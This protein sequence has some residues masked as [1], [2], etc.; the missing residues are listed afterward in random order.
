MKLGEMVT[1][2]GLE[3]VSL[4]GNSPVQFACVQWLLWESW[5]WQEHG[6]ILSLSVLAAIIL[7]RLLYLGLEMEGP[8]P[9]VSWAFHLLNGCHCPLRGG[10]SPRCWSRSIECWVW[11]YSIPVCA[12]SSPSNGTYTQ[13]RIALGVRESGLCTRCG[14]ECTLAGPGTKAQFSCSVVSDSLQPH[15]PQHARPPCPLPTPR[16]HSH[17]C[18]LSQWCHPTISYSVVPFSSH[19]Q[20]FSASGSFPLSQ[21]LASGG[22]RIGVSDSAS[23]LPMNIQDWFPLGLTGWVSLQSKGLSGVFNTTV[24]KH[25]FFGTQLSLGLYKCEW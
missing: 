22:Q 25:Q 18:P 10:S 2:F 6:V 8:E 9:Y 11:A 16:V 24:H 20:S 15:E 4:C 1:H 12:P 19:L 17:L 13:S 3:G 5:I 23:V 21:F 14:P 7:V